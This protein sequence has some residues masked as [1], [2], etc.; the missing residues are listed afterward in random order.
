MTKTE[1][2]PETPGS[3]RSLPRTSREPPGTQKWLFQRQNTHA[4]QTSPLS[5]D[6]LHTQ[7]IISFGLRFRV[8]SLG[9]ASPSPDPLPFIRW[10][11]QANHHTIRSTQ[12]I[13]SFG[14]QFRVCSVIQCLLPALSY[15]GLHTQTIISFGL[16]FRVC[17]L[18]LHTMDCTRKP[19]Y[20]SAFDSGFAPWEGFAPPQTPPFHTMDCPRKPSYHTISCEPQFRP[21]VN[22]P[23]TY[24][25]LHLKQSAVAELRAAHLDKQGLSI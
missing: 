7:T 3:S 14:L 9:G 10:I 17:P 12:T 1:G 20:H 13:I 6:G 21:P 19:S 5:Y 22:R 25:D 11:A 18:P 23:T 24:P 16:R 8:C 2:L 15:D 4:F